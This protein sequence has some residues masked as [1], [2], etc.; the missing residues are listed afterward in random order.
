MDVYLTMSHPNS[1]SEKLQVQEPSSSSQ[2]SGPTKGRFWFD[3]ELDYDGSKLSGEERQQMRDGYAD[4][5][6]NAKDRVPQE[7]PNV[8]L[9][10]K[11]AATP[12]RVSIASDSLSLRLLQ[13]A[14]TATSSQQADKKGKVVD[15]GSQSSAVLPDTD[16]LEKKAR[17]K[18][19]SLRLGDHFAKG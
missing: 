10:N 12:P 11:E 5:E 6:D 4:I 3:I 17:E 7:G 8:A 14:S 18:L 9:S 13:G 15:H 2:S 19:L 16:E 1:P